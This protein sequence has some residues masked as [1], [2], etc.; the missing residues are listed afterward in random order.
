VVCSNTAPLV[1][2]ERAPRRNRALQW[3][4]G[5]PRWANRFKTEGRTG[6]RSRCGAGQ[7]RSDA[8]KR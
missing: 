2:Q 6:K 3:A 7:P 8:G 5:P 1:K 4:Q